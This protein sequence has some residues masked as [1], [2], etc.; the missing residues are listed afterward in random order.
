MRNSP[1]SS[2]MQLALE[3]R[4]PLN[5]DHW[6]PSC[7][8]FPF[9]ANTRGDYFPIWGTCLGF[10]EL[11]YLT[12]GRLLLSLTNTRGIPL[13]VVFTNGTNFMVSKQPLCT[14][15]HN[16]CVFSQIPFILNSCYCYYNY[17]SVIYP[18]HCHHHTWCI[19]YICLSWPCIILAWNAFSLWITECHWGVITADLQILSRAG[20]SEGSHQIFWMRWPPSRYQPMSTSGASRL[21]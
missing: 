14:N 20:C 21:M 2:P 7:I 18:L 19:S 12:S 6:A 15:N 9:Q 17:P 4:W 1:S 8:R 13:P 3:P 10:E 5:K 16:T 11:T